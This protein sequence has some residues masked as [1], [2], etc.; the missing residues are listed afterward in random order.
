MGTG[1]PSIYVETMVAHWFSR[2]KSS[3]K[4]RALARPPGKKIL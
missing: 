1:I 2:L 3:R 4:V